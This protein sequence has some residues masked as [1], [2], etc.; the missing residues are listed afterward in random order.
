MVS[1]EALVNKFIEKIN[2]YEKNDQKIFNE[3]MN[4]RKLENKKSNQEKNRENIKNNEL[5]K[6]NKADEKLN[7]IIIKKR[8]CE[9]PLYFEKKE[10]KYK[11]DINTKIKKE[12]EELLKYK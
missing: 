4:Q 7:K 8:K 2:F 10:I 3:I 9:P 6:K 12:N 5:L 1:K 11:V